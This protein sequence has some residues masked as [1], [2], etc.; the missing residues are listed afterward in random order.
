MKFLLSFLQEL[1]AKPYGATLRVYP[2]SAPLRR[3]TFL[4][5]FSDQDSMTMLMA[6]G[7]L[8]S[9]DGSRL[10]VMKT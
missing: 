3:N 1:F 7:D 6:Q 10:D 2:P 8:R 5:R 9:S 4:I